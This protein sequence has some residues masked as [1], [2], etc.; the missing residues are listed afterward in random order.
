MKWARYLPIKKEEQEG[1]LRTWNFQGRGTGEIAYLWNCYGFII[2]KE[3]RF[4]DKYFGWQDKITYCGFSR[5][6]DFWYWNFQLGLE[7][8]NSNLEKYL[9][10]STDFNAL[11]IL[12]KHFWISFVCVIMTDTQHYTVLKNGKQTPQTMFI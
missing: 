5:D 8:G 1:W 4:I 6:L 10:T 11:I 7:I 9:P 12:K 3:M 2:K